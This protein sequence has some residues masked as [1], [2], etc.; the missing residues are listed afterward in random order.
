M[1]VTTDL[2]VIRDNLYKIRE[3][4]KDRT[5]TLMVKADAYNH[6]AGSRFG[7]LDRNA[8]GKHRRSRR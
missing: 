4:V 3:R 7:S 2:S 1:T 8:A 6:G 5:L